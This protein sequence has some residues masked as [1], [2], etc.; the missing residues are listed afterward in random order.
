MKV[1]KKTWEEKVTIVEESFLRSKNNPS[2]AYLF[3]QNLFFLSPKI[4]KYFEKTDFE[5]QH[6]AL[7][8]GLNFLFGHLDKSD[9]NSRDQILRIA[10]THSQTG[11]NI[12]PHHYYYWIEALLLTA[13]QCDKDWYDDME[14][15]WREVVSFP[16]YFIISMYFT[17][18]KNN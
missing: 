2:M 3:Y 9:H 17:P 15:Y 1:R 7:L 11:L 8:N 16:V 18:E 10:K 14:Y 4:K 6:K 12:H 13:K 5:H